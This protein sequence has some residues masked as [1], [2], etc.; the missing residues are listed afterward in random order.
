[1][2][3]RRSGDNADRFSETPV[4]A[5]SNTALYIPQAV[6]LL[7]SFRLHRSPLVRLLSLSFVCALALAVG[8][9][10]A[11]A[12]AATT[13]QQ[14]QAKALDALKV[15]EGTGAIWRCALSPNPVVTP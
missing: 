5:V 15:S 3:K 7:T 9:A 1:M 12:S 2:P 13:Q 11:V 8:L 4:V 6:C 10:P 14:A